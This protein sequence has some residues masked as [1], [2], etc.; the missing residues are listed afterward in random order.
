MSA[1]WADGLLAMHFL[2]VLFMLLGFPLAVLLR[3]RGLRLVH[4]LGLTSY[5]LLAVL[6]WYCPLTIGEEFFRGQAAPDFSYQGSFLASWFERL[7]YVEHWGA[8]LWI[9]RVLAGLYLAVSL[10]SWW[11][12]PARRARPGGSNEK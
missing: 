5:I 10:S 2:W 7:I 6:N 3:S 4:A 12:W 9:F 8:P 11:W 1:F